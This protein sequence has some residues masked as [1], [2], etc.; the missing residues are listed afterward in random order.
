[1]SG[2]FYPPP[3]PFV[4]GNQPYAGPNAIPQS[5]PA[6][7]PLYAPISVATLATILASWQPLPQPMQ[8]APVVT[9]S[10]P[11]ATPYTFAGSVNQRILASSWDDNIWTVIHVA[12]I[13]SQAPPPPQVPSS[14]ANLRILLQ[15]WDAPPPLPQT[16]APIAA[17]L[18][19][20]S[21]P[22]P[23]SSAGFANLI[24]LN[25]PPAYAIPR[26]GTIASTLPA[27][28]PPPPVQYASVRVLL[29]AWDAPPPT[30]VWYGPGFGTH[31]VKPSQP[32][33]LSR[34]V[35]AALI[36]SWRPPVWWPLPSLVQQPVSGPFFIP[37]TQKTV[38]FPA[39]PSKQPPV[40][41][42]TIINP[43]ATTYL[44]PQP[45]VGLPP[46]FPIWMYNP[47]FPPVL[48]NNMA[49]MVALEELGIGWTPNYLPPYTPPSVPPVPQVT[50]SATLPA[51]TVDDFNPTGWE[52]GFTTRLVLLPSPS[53]TSLIGLNSAGVP[54]GWKVELLNVSSTLALSIE[55]DE[56]ATLGASFFTSGGAPYTLNF[57]AGRF[58]E[59]VQYLNGW[60]IL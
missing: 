54:D 5:G 56:S 20:P 51:G 59:W 9:P 32:P 4:G 6:P 52:A 12:S 40:D 31:Y 57:Q 41:M 24:A 36:E 34:V 44:G 3:P 19:R 58:I 55:N 1:M 38:W 11:A 16:T 7:R 17:Q 49:E 23:V 25:Q 50:V 18:P 8:R 15:A 45:E 22:P 27:P 10:G 37:V 14:Q 13:G 43:D 47:V 42:N 46:N 30:F 33:P 39:Q 26:A 53:T 60:M 35:Q 28:S 2:A 21:P 48:V 29:Q